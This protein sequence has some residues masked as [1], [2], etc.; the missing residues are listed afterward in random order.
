MAQFGTLKAKLGESS[1]IKLIVKVKDFAS[2]TIDFKEQSAVID[3]FLDMVTAV[4]GEIGKHA[5]TSVDVPA[6]PFNMA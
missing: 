3:G 6:L 4:L 5:G 2:S 1:K